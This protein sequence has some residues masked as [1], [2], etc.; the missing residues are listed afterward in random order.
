MFFIIRVYLIV[1]P[2][3]TVC[4][5]H[6]LLKTYLGYSTIEIFTPL[7]PPQK[8]KM[9]SFLGGRNFFLTILVIRYE[10]INLQEATLVYLGRPKI[11][12]GLAGS[13]RPLPATSKSQNTPFL[14]KNSSFWRGS[15]RF[16]FLNTFTIWYGFMSL[17]NQIYMY[18]RWSKNF[19]ETPAPFQPLSATSKVKMLHSF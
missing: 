4:F 11:F 16:C 3:N 12:T 13:F 14:A 19:I 8:K 6:T 17:R 1:K 15:R 10:H 2:R 7:P 9:T 18:M 5:S